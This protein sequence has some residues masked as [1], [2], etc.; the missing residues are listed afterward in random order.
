MFRRVMVVVPESGRYVCATVQEDGQMRV[1]IVGDWRNELLE[2]E[3][4]IS[5]R[6]LILPEIEESLVDKPY[7]VWGSSW[8]S[9]D[10]NY[11]L[12]YFQTALEKG[13]EFPE[14]LLKD[15]EFLTKCLR[16]KK[17]R[18]W[19]AVPLRDNS[20]F[21]R[22][23]AVLLGFKALTDIRNNKFPGITVEV[24]DQDSA[25]LLP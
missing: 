7:F 16:S 6:G 2:E 19:G 14:I 8:T 15:L 22:L 12:Q 5:F 9:F 13:L 3:N 21:S 23:Y 4:D 17:S 10:Q 1:R 18:D 25:G 20:K 11:W 24:V